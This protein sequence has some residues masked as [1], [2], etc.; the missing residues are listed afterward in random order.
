M[1]ARLGSLATLNHYRATHIEAK[2]TPLLVQL[3]RLDYWRLLVRC[4]NDYKVFTVNW[5]ES[6]TLTQ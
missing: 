5:S 2:D 4:R 1:R 3:R 6:V